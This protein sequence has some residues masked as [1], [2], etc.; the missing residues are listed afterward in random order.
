MFD[1]DDIEL[2]SENERLSSSHTYSPDTSSMRKRRLAM[3]GLVS[4]LTIP[5]HVSEV[6]GENASCD[7]SLEDSESEEEN[8][9]NPSPGHVKRQV[10]TIEAAVLDTDEVTEGDLR[11][12]F[13]PSVVPTT[14]DREIGT[15]GFE[16]KRPTDGPPA[17]KI[18][19][20]DFG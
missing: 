19:T 16:P 10:E 20:A 13:C 7:N 3:N 15:V 8:S 12:P 5:D 11:D 6:D 14:E 2:S 17:R 9:S 18:G 4:D 1:C